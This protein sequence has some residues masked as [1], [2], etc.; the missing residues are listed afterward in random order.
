MLAE[1]AYRCPL[2]DIGL[3]SRLD[4]Q[5]HCSPDEGYCCGK[6]FKFFDEREEADDCCQDD[7]EDA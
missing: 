1:E 3:N 7:L 4:A 2:C 5:T 6:C